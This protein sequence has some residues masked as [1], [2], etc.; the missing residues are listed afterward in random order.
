MLSPHLFRFCV[1]VLIVGLALSVRSDPEDHDVVPVIVKSDVVE[2]DHL[3]NGKYT[4]RSTFKLNLQSDNKYSVS[5]VSKVV[6]QDD[7]VGAFKN[8]LSGEDLYN[9]RFRKQESKQADYIYMSIPA[10]ALQRS[11]FKEDILLY[12]GD[13][14][15][16]MGGNYQSPVIGL[17][18]ACDAA[19]LVEPTTFLTRI[20]VGDAQESM[21]IPVQ[22]TG[23]KPASLQHVKVS[24]VDAKTGKVV[25]EDAQQPQQ[26]FL[27]RYWYLVLAMI[28]Y[29]M[30][31][32]A[33]APQKAKSK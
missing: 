14:G 18:R 32:P 5:E 15:N 11:G 25:E 21:I 27:R 6:L 30:L 4:A 28:F 24:V 13:D 16:I 8:L 19:K 26:S 22:A 3:I 1:L 29:V 12:V 20:K 31:S 33:E 23:P 17:P 2:L 7:I 9:V 10:C